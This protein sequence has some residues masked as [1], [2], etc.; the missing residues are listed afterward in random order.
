MKI[1]IENTPHRFFDGKEEYLTFK[2][3]WGK[4]MLDK[5]ERKKLHNIHHFIY[6]LICGR[7]LT[8][9]YS[10]VTTRRKLEHGAVMNQGI[11][12][13]R[14]ELNR[15]ALAATDCSTPRPKTQTSW[16]G[17]VKESYESGHWDWAS[18][19]VDAELKPFNYS[20]FIKPLSEIIIELNDIVPSIPWL[21]N[22]YYNYF[23]PNEITFDSIWNMYGNEEFK[24]PASITWHWCS[25]EDKPQKLKEL[26]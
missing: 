18:N 11:Y 21:S 3:N 25:I 6:N 17:K 19:F 13:A 16:W 24:K 10:L 23:M 20:T 15:L 9:C 4:L 26:I 22:T 1:Q 2:K 14:R 7:D 8:R 12:E 5:E